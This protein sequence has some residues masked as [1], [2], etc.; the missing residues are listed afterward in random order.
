[1]AS[2]TY[3]FQNKMIDQIFRGQAYTFPTTLYVSLFTTAPT[4]LGTDGTEVSTAN[5]GYARVAVP[6]SLT[7]WSG[8]QGAGTTTVSTGNTGST[9][10]NVQITFGTPTANW[11]SVVAQGIWDAATGGNLLVFNTLTTAKT[12]NNGD[13]APY[14]AT[15]TLDVNIS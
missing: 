9:N 2:T 13:P 14:F 3:Y 7:E 12:V 4:A 11:G 5:T 8:T 15:G 6:A 10:N 1:M